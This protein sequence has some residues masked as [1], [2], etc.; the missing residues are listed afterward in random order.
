[1][2]TL[3]RRTFLRGVG[4]SM[5]LPL[6][7]AMIPARALAAG[8]LPK[9]PVRL[10]WVYFPNG[11]VR[12]DWTPRGEGK[13]FEFN[14]T[15]AS[16]ADVRDD[17]T[18][19][20]NLAHNKARP[21]GDGAGS[22]SRSGATFL[23]ATQAKK[24]AGKDIYL[25]ESIDQAI[26]RQIG[27]QTRL[28]SLELGIDPS[29]KEGR[30]DSG[31]SC[32]YLSNISW[33]TPTQPCGVEINPRR[34]F[35]RLFGTTGQDAEEFKQRSADR[36]SVLDFVAE[37]ASSLQ[38]QVGKTDRRKL[39]EYFES[40]RA[41]EKQL[42]RMASLPPIKL[43]PSG[44]VLRSELTEFAAMSRDARKDAFVDHIRMM[45]DLMALAYQTDATRIIT[46]MLANA[47][48]NRAYV[49]LGIKSGHHQLTHSVGQKEMIQK[50]DQFL[51]EEFARFLTKLKSIPEGDGT[52]LDNC[53]ITFGSAMGDGRKHD[54]G[55]LPIILAGRGGGI[56]AGRHIA[57]A[58]EVP[59]AN[60]FVSVAHR[61]G[62]KVEQF[63]DSTGS[64]EKV[65]G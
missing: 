28:S 20:S 12:D 52:L 32:I 6:L 41:V 24:T 65:L 31:Y 59:L 54:H 35:D 1:M 38:R 27:N 36:Q 25:G 13:E 10:G 16:L 33:R 18:L 47:Q 53:L 62:A 64:L 57:L 37:D 3:P 17:V 44:P 48:T 23:T 11:M 14:K 4:V 55:K 22:H 43:P 2:K 21:N 46:F 63:G 34:A 61:A 40:V 39:D 19:L 51:T 49:N 26:A 45:Y 5:G 60:L 50:I 56:D 58:D 42:D 30:C 29:R 7:E 9:P 8:T 15:N